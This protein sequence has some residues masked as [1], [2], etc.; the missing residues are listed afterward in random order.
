MLIDS[1][2]HYYCTQGQV[3]ERSAVAYPGLLT[4]RVAPIAHKAQDKQQIPRR[5]PERR[6]GLGMTRIT[7][8]QEKGH[9]RREAPAWKSCAKTD[10][11]PR[12]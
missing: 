7:A 8:C 5:R 10:F 1:E 12:Q 9:T 6:A 4:N 3:T 11:L 2:V